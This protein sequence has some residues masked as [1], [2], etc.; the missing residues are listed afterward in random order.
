MCWYCGES[1]WFKE[2]SS[3][4]ISWLLLLFFFLKIE[5]SKKNK[6]TKNN[7]ILDKKCHP[8]SFVTNAVI[9][10]LLL[11]H[12]VHTMIWYKPK[13]FKMD[14]VFLVK[15]SEFKIIIEKKCL[16]K[17]V[18]TQ[19]WASKY[20]LSRENY[21]GLQTNLSFDRFSERFVQDSNTSILT[22]FLRH[23]WINVWV[24]KICTL[25]WN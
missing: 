23:H 8:V 15:K 19:R 25:H 11:F 12:F 3:I 18:V 14:A 13:L 24:F 6:Q 21:F 4:I 7:V 1:S 16:R 20:S 2:I 22:K 10:V 17:L 5:K 9:L